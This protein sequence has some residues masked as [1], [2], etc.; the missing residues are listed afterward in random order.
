[1]CLKADDMA[2][3]LAW[4]GLK[5]LSML[6]AALH[7]GVA[8]QVAAFL[9]R[10]AEAS[11]RDLPHSKPGDLKRLPKAVLSTHLYGVRNHL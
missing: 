4:H 2:K 5:I 10:L 7:T 8:F 9:K 6:Q 3:L 1:M 11:L